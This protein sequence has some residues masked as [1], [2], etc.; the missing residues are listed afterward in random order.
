MLLTPLARFPQIARTTVG[1]VQLSQSRPMLPQSLKWRKRTLSYIRIPVGADTIAAI[2]PAMRGRSPSRRCSNVAAQAGRAD[3]AGAG[4]S[5]ALGLVPA[6]LRPFTS[7]LTMAASATRST[8]YAAALLDRAGPACRVTEGL[9]EL[10][11]R[12]VMP[13][14]AMAA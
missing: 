7:P 8:L 6:M 1:D 10:V 13:I 9:D 14:V 2:E 11:A 3:A 5:Q 4:G 12:A